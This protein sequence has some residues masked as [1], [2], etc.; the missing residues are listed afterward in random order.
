MPSGYVF[1]VFTNSVF[2]EFIIQDFELHSAGFG[3]NK[4]DSH[5]KTTYPLKNTSQFQDKLTTETNQ[6]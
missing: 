5:K 1:H 3:Q 2:S 6:I 4:K